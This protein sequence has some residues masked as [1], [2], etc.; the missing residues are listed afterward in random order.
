MIRV[1]RGFIYDHESI[2]IIKGTSVRGGL[3]HDYLSRIDSVPVVTKAMAAKVYREVM[4][5]QEN[6]WWRKWLK[7]SFVVIWPRYFHRFT[8]FATYRELIGE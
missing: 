6:S 5:V 4:T 3:V 8:V 7:S 2:P 1:P